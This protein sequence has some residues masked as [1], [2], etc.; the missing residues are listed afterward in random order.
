LIVND[1]S[2]LKYLNQSDLNDFM[3]FIAYVCIWIVKIFIIEY[4]KKFDETIL[5]I[6]VVNDIKHIE[7]ADEVPK[8][9]LEKMLACRNIDGMETT[10]TE[11]L[12]TEIETNFDENTKNPKSSTTSET[13]ANPEEK[14]SYIS[15]IDVSNKQNPKISCEISGH[16][17]AYIIVM[18]ELEILKELKS[19]ILFLLEEEHKMLLP[20]KLSETEIL[21]IFQKKYDESINF[22]KLIKFKFYKIG[23][24]EFKKI[25][26]KAVNNFIEII[27]K[28]L[29]KNIS[30]DNIGKIL[31]L[32]TD[33]FVLKNSENFAE[34][35]E[36]LN[37]F[38]NFR[39]TICEKDGIL[40]KAS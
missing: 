37:K 18:P 34:L 8:F 35:Y 16:N 10:S 24:P 39:E 14:T 31:S 11:S 3:T 1:S 23:I 25:N 12:N 19:L 40:V 30:Q 15:E 28:I 17:N 36:N 32:F 21:S 27:Q 20:K 9:K 13:T 33:N 22:G 29:S 5:E 4:P 2:L 26:N 38:Y 6:V 7:A